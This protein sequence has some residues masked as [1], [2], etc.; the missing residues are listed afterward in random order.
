MDYFTIQLTMLYLCVRDSNWFVDLI[1]GGTLNCC[2]IK[3]LA[4]ET[5]TQLT[6]H[7]VLCLEQGILPALQIEF[8]LYCLFYVK[9][10]HLLN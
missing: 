8:L 6:A 7:N 9:L 5:T 10:S 2:K 3:V 1:S 4:E